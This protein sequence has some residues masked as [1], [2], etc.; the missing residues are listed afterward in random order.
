MRNTHNLPW[1]VKSSGRIL[2][3][4]SLEQIEKLL[5][6][7]EI[8]VLDEVAQ[9]QRR[10]RYIRDV[11]EFQRI[12][13]DIR[14]EATGDIG[15]KTFTESTEGQTASLTEPLSSHLVDELTDEIGFSSNNK[16]NEIV[17]DNVEEVILRPKGSPVVNSR[18]QSGAHGDRAVSQQ[19]DAASKWLWWA[20]GLII[21]LVASFIGYKRFVQTPMEMEAS[22]KDLVARGQQLMD[23]GRLPDA[24]EA[25]KKAYS[26]DP[27]NSSYYHYLGPL[28]VQYEGQTVLGR[29]LLD[30]ALETNSQFRPHILTSMGLADLK[31]G[32]WR[33]ADE[34]FQ[35]ALNIN[36]NYAP[37]IVNRGV[38]S[39]RK[40]DY[41][42][43]KSFFETALIK[44]AD[45]GAVQ[46]LLAESMIQVAQTEKKFQLL[47]EAIARLD[48]YQKDNLAYRQESLL[49]IAYLQAA[50]EQGQQAEENITRLLDVDPSATDLHTHNIFIARDPINWNQLLSYCLSTVRGLKATGR[51]AALT[52]LCYLKAN[53]HQEA[54]SEIQTALQRNPKDPLVQAVGAYVLQSIGQEQSGGVSLG[55]ALEF[56]RGSDFRLPLLLQARLY[57]ENGDLASSKEYWKRLLNH[58]SQSLEAYSGL[59]KIAFEEDRREEFRRYIQPV[60]A[61]ADYIPV[62]SLIV[63]ARKKGWDL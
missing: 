15:D 55:K 19:A 11:S 63:Q 43:A 24:L 50:T 33:G 32:N 51:V 26:L 60:K 29:R 5:K 49:M 38:L 6:T 25:F 62:T 56:D 10:F 21:V 35:Q 34:H 41:S 13:D 53:K 42:R 61:K 39:L 48:Q 44:G 36:P 16:M 30:Q 7:R 40:K 45:D 17:Y 23:E 8:V 9:P 52:G 58:G 59:A 14:R 27:T 22:S 54:N 3:P 4:F 37:A 1:L 47:K 57:Y 28:I 18:Y 46:L 12:V 2:G 31:D 20:T